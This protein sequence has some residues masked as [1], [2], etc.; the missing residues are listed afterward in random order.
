MDFGYIGGQGAGVADAGGATIPNGIETE[1]VKVGSE[2]GLVVVVGDDAGAGG[3]GG[4]DPG[5][6]AQAALDGLF[7]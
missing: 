6:G 1:G 2:A 5:R 3:E 7:S 4:L